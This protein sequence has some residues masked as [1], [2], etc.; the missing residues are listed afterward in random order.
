MDTASEAEMPVHPD[1]CATHRGFPV[2][3][4]LKMQC[5]FVETPAI[6]EQ[7][8]NRRPESQGHRKAQ[9]EA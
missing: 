6:S 4:S 3:A 5:E 7:P 1:P 8:R 9:S 2:E